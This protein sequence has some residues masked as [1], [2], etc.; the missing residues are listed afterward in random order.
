LENISWHF[1]KHFLGPKYQ[2][3]LF[4]FSH[5]YL[6]NLYQ[7]G[8]QCST[9]AYIRNQQQ[10][11]TS[12]SSCNVQSFTIFHIQQIQKAC[13]LFFLSFF[14]LQWRSFRRLALV[15]DP[16]HPSQRNPQPHN[17]RRELSVFSGGNWA[18]GCC[19]CSLDCC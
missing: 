9:K 17:P 10:Y 15:P 1:H 5:N 3:S 13:S 14:F 8:V 7:N 12:E 6:P 2:S 19:C 16:A 18:S 11:D 4:S